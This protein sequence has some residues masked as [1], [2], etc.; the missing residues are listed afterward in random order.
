MYL[1]L[2]LDFSA[3][4]LFVFMLVIKMSRL[5]NYGDNLTGKRLTG[6][7]ITE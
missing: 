1:E 4:G 5:H 6:F 3:S 2:C 7:I